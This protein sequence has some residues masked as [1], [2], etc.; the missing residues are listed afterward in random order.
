[1]SSPPSHQ[2][3]MSFEGLLG[4]DPTTQLLS[5][6]PL[7]S[8]FPRYDPMS[9]YDSVRKTPIDYRLRK[10]IRV[11]DGFLVSPLAPPAPLSLGQTLVG[12]GPGHATPTISYMTHSALSDAPVTI[13]DPNSAPDWDSM[14]MGGLGGL[15]TDG[16]QR[17]DSSSFFNYQ[18]PTESARGCPD[19]PR[20]TSPSYIWA[21]S[22]VPNM[23]SA[24]PSSG[25]FGRS[26][27]PHAE[28]PLM[29]S[30]PFDATQPQLASQTSPDTALAGRL[31]PGPLRH[32]SASFL[33]YQHP[34]DSVHAFPH[35][36]RSVSAPYIWTMPNVRSPPAGKRLRPGPKPKPKT[37]KKGG[38]ETG[39]DKEDETPLSP[40]KKA[41]VFGPDLS[42]VQPR[43]P[44]DSQPQLAIEPP[45]SSTLSID[46]QSA[47]GLPRNFL[48]KLYMT[49]LTLDGSMTGQPIKRFKCLIE[50]CERHFPRKSA[51]HSHIQTHL[52]DKPFVCN[53][54]DW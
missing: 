17:H 22:S 36:S 49:F 2:T 37:P 48:E 42:A 14:D 53:A 43:P 21:M 33:H 52:E 29:G 24:L 5:S 7:Q 12:S 6:P 27:S 38:K 8:S 44:S 18:P 28:S 47:S 54:E 30:D 15:Q 11:D 51:I 3:Y 20:S 45:R 50:G 1:M 31:P 19:I 10:R 41:L 26:L 16:I 32:A 34:A 40:P 4:A 25:F 35:V 13:A 9:P 23:P 39:S 46:G